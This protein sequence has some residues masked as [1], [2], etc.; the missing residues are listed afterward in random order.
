MSVFDQASPQ[1]RQLGQALRRLREDADLS[2]M[3]LARRSGLSQSKISRVENAQQLPSTAD[4]RRWLEAANATDQQFIEL[5]QLREQAATESV[6]WR[7]HLR[8]GLSAVQAEVKATEAA[9]TRTREY[10]PTIIPGLLQASAYA[11]GRAEARHGAGDP[12]VAEWVAAVADRQLLL[13]EEGRRF[14]FI[15]GEAALRWWP[16]PASIMR[17]QLHHLIGLAELANVSIGILALNQ[18]V[19]W[20]THAFV[21]YDQ[22][23][24]QTLV[25]LELLA[26]GQNLRDPED[27]GRFQ[28]AFDQLWDTALIGR[29]AVA[30]LERLTAEIR[31]VDQG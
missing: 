9:A 28:A 14:D 22:G 3:E 5:E 17:A 23:Q 15:I 2:G 10:Q 20:H 19:P 13:Y 8:R 29:Q 11:R 6:A 1:R 4:V 31:E 16:G 27:V 30:M 24:E 26:G 25:H 7:Q 18:V 21:M 12:K